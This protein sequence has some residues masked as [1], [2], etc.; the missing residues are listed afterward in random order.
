M[1]RGG[2]RRRG[3]S[4]GRGLGRQLQTR[5]CRRAGRRRREG[6]FRRFLQLGFYGDEIIF[7]RCA[8][9][10]VLLRHHLPHP[11]SPRHL[12]HLLLGSHPVPHLRGGGWCIRVLIKERL[13]T[14]MCSRSSSSLVNLLVAEQR[15]QVTAVPEGG[16][17]VVGWE[18]YHALART[19]KQVI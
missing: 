16:C 18:L 11:C 15:A 4:R 7:L 2:C 6:G 3:G 5:S 17:M 12:L 8:S 14:T 13:P 1:G 10:C 9:I 19:R